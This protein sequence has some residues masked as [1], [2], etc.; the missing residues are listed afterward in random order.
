MSVNPDTS[1]FLMWF[2]NPSGNLYIYFLAISWSHPP[3]A[4]LYDSDNFPIDLPKFTLPTSNALTWP[5]TY[6]YS[7]SKHW[8]Q[9]YLWNVKIKPWALQTFQMLWLDFPWPPNLTSS[10]NL[11]HEMCPLHLIIQSLPSVP[12]M[13]QAFSSHRD[14]LK[15]CPS[16]LLWVEL[17]SPKGCVQVLIFSTCELTFFGNKVFTEMIRLRRNH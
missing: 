3:V 11:F 4:H 17:C 12:Q 8:S 7:F 13:H 6:P 1:I 15:C 14:H 2:T 10:A 5:N 16:H 9:T